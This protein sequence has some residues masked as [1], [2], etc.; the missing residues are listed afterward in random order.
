MTEKW[1]PP[2]EKYK[3]RER[4]ITGLSVGASLILI[5][6]IYVINLPNSLWDSIV[7]FFNNIALRQVPNTAISLPAPAFPAGHAVLYN[8]LFQLC[9]GIVILQIV[10]L[11]LRLMMHSRINKT[12]ETI[13]NFVYWSGSAYLVTT[14]L[15]TTASLTDWFAF[16]AGIFVIAGLSFIV[17]AIVLLTKR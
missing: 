7:R 6:I 9:V 11:F 17:R 13:G 3:M 5:G 8:A 15:N 10:I 16:W 4:L 2:A 1:N 12:A 14:Y